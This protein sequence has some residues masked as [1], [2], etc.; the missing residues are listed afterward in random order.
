MCFNL[1][2]SCLSLAV[3]RGN[4]IGLFDIRSASMSGYFSLAIITLFPAPG[5]LQTSISPNTT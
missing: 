2:Y 1:D 4:M 5:K 3:V